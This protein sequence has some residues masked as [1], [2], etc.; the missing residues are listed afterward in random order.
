MKE[1]IAKILS[2]LFEREVSPDEDVSMENEYKWDSMR[3]I[4]IIMTIE[5]ELG[6]SFPPADIPTLTSMKKIIRKVEELKA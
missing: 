6:I 3:H 1:K 4:E 5:E 2:V